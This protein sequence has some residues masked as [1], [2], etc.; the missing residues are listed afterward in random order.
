MTVR[1]RFDRVDATPSPDCASR[2]TMA[3]LTME[4]DGATAT[5]VRAPRSRVYRDHVVVPQFNLADWS[6][7]RWWHLW[8]EIGDAIG[9]K[10]GFEHRHGLASA[11]DGF[12]LPKLSM[13][14]SSGRMHLKWSRW[15]PEHAEI[16]FVDEAEPFVSRDDLET[17]FRRGA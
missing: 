3:A 17:E 5:S 9:Q 2:Q 6:A 1:F 8:H 13:V 4:A 7:N 12:V 15:A 11:G 10:P 16:E 14:S